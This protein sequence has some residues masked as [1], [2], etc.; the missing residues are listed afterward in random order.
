MIPRRAAQ[1]VTKDDIRKPLSVHKA[2]ATTKLQKAH[3]KFNCLDINS[4]FY[5]FRI[6]F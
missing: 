6:H 2:T 5:H 4:E 1:P 3:R